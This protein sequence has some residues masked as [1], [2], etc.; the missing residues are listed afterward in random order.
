MLKFF[1]KRKP[2]KSEDASS[3]SAGDDTGS[4]YSILLKPD[5]KVKLVS[6]DLKQCLLSNNVYDV[7]SVLPDNLKHI[8][9]SVSRSK[10]STTEKCLFNDT[11]WTWKFREHRGDAVMACLVNHADFNH[12]SD[13]DASHVIDD[14]GDELFSHSPSSMCVTTIE[15]FELLK[16][17]KQ[18]D[19]MFSPEEGKLKSM[20]DVINSANIIKELQSSLLDICLL[21]TSDAADDL[22]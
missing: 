15:G 13:T 14:S 18:F 20:V 19:K 10:N 2:G 22:A 16:T 11:P 8:C 17:N 21:Y 4:E 12:T 1:G 9:Q 5:G 6:I 7:N 3:A